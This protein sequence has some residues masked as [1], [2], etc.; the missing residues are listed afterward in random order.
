MLSRSILVVICAVLA[1]V[2]TASAQQPAGVTRPKDPRPSRTLL[3]TAGSS[4]AARP[5][6]GNAFLLET[7][8]GSVGSLAG[9]GIGLGLASACESE[10]LGCEIV[11]IVTGGALGIAGAATGVALTARHTGSSRSAA[12]AVLGALVGTGVGLGVHYL[13]NRASDRNLGDASVVPIFVISQG[14]LAA[15][16]SRLLGTD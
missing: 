6:G 8:G 1:P 4:T 5:K 11:S 9:I 7:L 14:V 15:M 16:G 3:A 10:D 2:D 12:G 13:V